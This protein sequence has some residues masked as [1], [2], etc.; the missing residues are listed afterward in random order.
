M[1]YLKY[2]AS[3][4]I[5]Q[6]LNPFGIW[7][8]ILHNSGQ[9]IAVLRSRFSKIVT[10]SVPMSL[11]FEGFWTV[12]NGGLDIQSSHSWNLITQR[13]AYDLIIT[14]K[15]GKKY[16]FDGSKAENYYAFGQDVLAP[17]DGMVIKVQNNIRD[18]VYAGTGTINLRTQDMR[19]NYLIIRHA[20]SV[21]SFIAHLRQN[22]CRVKPG[23]FVKCGQVIAQC[24]NSGHSTEPHIHFHVQDHRNFYLAIG[25]PILFKNIEIEYNA[26]TA[27]KKVAY[28]YISKNCRVRNITTDKEHKEFSNEP[29]KEIAPAQGGLLSLFSSALNVLGLTVWLFFVYIWF[30]QPVLRVIIGR[31]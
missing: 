27:S 14:N 17:A 18:Y 22:S 8:S 30:I 20:D 1:I 29:D 5:W 28:G 21:Y 25:L 26:S 4:F 7:Q 9:I 23:D 31:S 10:P 19:G 16:N 24:G 15:D 13:Y 3:V 2:F 12:I 11:P 6:F